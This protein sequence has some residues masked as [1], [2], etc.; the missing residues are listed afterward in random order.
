M[1]GASSGEIIPL[2]GLDLLG[3]DGFEMDLPLLNAGD[4]FELQLLVDGPRRKLALSAR[5]AGQS[6]PMEVYRERRSS[7]IRRLGLTLSAMGTFIIA[8]FVIY[9]A[10]I[11]NSSQ[12]VTSVGLTLSVI[13]GFLTGSGLI[14]LYR[15]V[16]LRR[17]RT[18]HRHR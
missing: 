4:W 15:P 12:G 16:L 11:G 13:A 1:V 8:A 18:R 3:D 6:R 5:F 17:D 10:T 7:I 14:L 2:E 9:A